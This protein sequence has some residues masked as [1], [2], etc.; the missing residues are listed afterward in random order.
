MSRTRRAITLAALGLTGAA[1][2][3]EL[4]RPA[5]QRTWQGRVVGVPYDFRPP[6]WERVRSRWWNPQDPRL[7]TERAVGLGWDVNFARVLGRT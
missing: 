5:G 7:L 6:T 4:R 1:V 2:A 3:Q